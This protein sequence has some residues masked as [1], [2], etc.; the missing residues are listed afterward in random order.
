M[1]NTIFTDNV[2]YH[3]LWFS[4]AWMHG[5]GDGVHGGGGG[6]VCI[7]AGPKSGEVF[8]LGGFQVPAYA[9]ATVP[10]PFLIL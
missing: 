7:K 9:A 8:L 6:G 5:Q 3:R 4:N 2:G 10:L 1:C